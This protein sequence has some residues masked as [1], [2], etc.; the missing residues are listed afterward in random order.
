MSLSQR[1]SCLRSA[2]AGGGGLCRVSCPRFTMWGGEEGHW[3]GR[4]TW[5]GRKIEKECEVTE[6]EEKDEEGE[7]Y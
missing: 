3:G 4:G 7:D 6:E 2:G 5:G 1:C